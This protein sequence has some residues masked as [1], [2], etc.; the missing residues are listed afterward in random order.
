LQL[1]SNDETVQD[2]PGVGGV[3]NS[4]AAFEWLDEIMESNL[5]MSAILAIIHPKL[6][7]AGRKTFDYTRNAAKTAADLKGQNVLSRW[8]SV[9]NGLSVIGNRVTP[10][11]RDVNSRVQW[12]DLLITLGSYRDC[13]LELPGAGCSLEYGPGTVVG[14]SGMVLAHE[15][16]KFD[17]ERVCYA[18]F[19]RNNVHEWAT[20]R[21]EGWMNTEYYK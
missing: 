9:F 10:L 19:M 17:G 4:P 3:F 7:K 18:Y 16:P 5:V 1:N 21:G 12:Y 20:V 2:R 11:H 6:Y 8:T 15:V 13:T 14:L